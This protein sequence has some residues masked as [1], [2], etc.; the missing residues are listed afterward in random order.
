[1]AE[2]LQTKL[3]LIGIDWDPKV[4]HIPCLAH[5]INLVVQAF[6]EKLEV[7]NNSLSVT[8][9]KIRGIARSIRGS[10]LRW[11]SFQGCCQSCG[12]A[13]V[14]IP[15]DMPVCWN[16]TYR[17]IEQMVYL[18]RPIRRYLDDHHDKLGKY[19]LTAAEWE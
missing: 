4:Q 12:I 14:T 7:D 10:T 17:M 13:P 6:L 11:E 9:E 18:K 3:E 5:I 19:H 1:M 8:L 16:S 2:H 15:L